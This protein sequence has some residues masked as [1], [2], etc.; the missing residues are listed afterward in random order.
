MND[1]ELRARFL[2]LRESDARALRDFRV[3]V[4]ARTLRPLWLAGLA[5]AVLIV[6]TGLVIRRSSD[7]ERMQWSAGS[8]TTWRSPTASLLTASSHEL[9]APAPIL[10]S[11]LDGV[12]RST[13]RRTGARP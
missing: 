8:I 5:A 11:T 6:V 3:A 12:V 10:S 7:R 9:L 4:P 13:V 2:D 1:D